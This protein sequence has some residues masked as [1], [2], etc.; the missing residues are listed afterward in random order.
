V[1]EHSIIGKEE[2]ID[3][4][5]LFVALKASRHPLEGEEECVED[6]EEIP[7]LIGKL[8]TFV[9][10]DVVAV[11]GFIVIKGQVEQEMSDGFA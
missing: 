3:F 1:I 6:F 5:I 10:G 4:G 9:K 7:F 8:A 11:G 2:I